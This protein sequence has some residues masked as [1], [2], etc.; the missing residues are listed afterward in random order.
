MFL[1]F[2]ISEED[3]DG[4]KKVM[5]R[6]REACV[7]YGF[8]QIENHGIPLEL[9]T[10][11]MDLYK[12][13]FAC[14]DEDKLLVSPKSGSSI[15]AGYL[16]SPQNSAEKNEHFVFLPSSSGFNVYPNNPPHF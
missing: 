15:P 1:L 8:F 7:K 16:K 11:T 4:K 9:L 13:F 2:L 6:I 5:E 3:E 12:T 10:R 14:S